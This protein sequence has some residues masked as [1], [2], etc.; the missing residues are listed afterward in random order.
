M[1][2]YRINVNENKDERYGVPLSFLDIRG[3]AGEQ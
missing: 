3:S 1:V 2:A